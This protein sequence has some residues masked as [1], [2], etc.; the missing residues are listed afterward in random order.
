[1]TQKIKIAVIGAGLSGVTLAHTLKD[2]A[3]V[4]VYEKARGIGGRM[5]TRYKDSFQFD[6]GAQFFSA[7]SDEFKSFLKPFLDE[8]LVRNWKP[9]LVEIDQQGNV[10]NMTWDYD[11]YVASPKMNQL[12]KHIAQQCDVQLNVHID[13]L[14]QR[15]G[16][17]FLTYK[18]GQVYGPYDWVVSSAPAEQARDLLPFGFKHYNDICAVKMLGCYSLMIGLSDNLNLDWDAARIN[19][20]PINWIAVNSN[21]PDRENDY[22]L[23]LQTD[24][25][26]AEDNI[27]RDQTDVESILL[28]EAKRFL[29]IDD[30]NISYLSLHRWRYAST[31][32]T[33]ER[34]HAF[35]IDHS[36]NLAACGDWCINGHVE[37]AFLSAFHLSNEIKS[38]VL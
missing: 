12:C 25:N 20:S 1:M 36:M 15:D 18:N 16:L 28:N 24:N 21:K 3:D 35:L 6:H 5:S 17:W 29:P 13:A 38:S 14:E 33:Y 23:I 37:S 34:D 7:R 22:S 27:E 31:G 4:T 2:V 9:G 11:H 10:S 32:K 19:G 30:R 8:G 26:W